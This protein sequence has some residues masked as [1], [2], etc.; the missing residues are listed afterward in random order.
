M[1]VYFQLFFQTKSKTSSF[2]YS[3]SGRVPNDESGA[4]GTETVHAIERRDVEETFNRQGSENRKSLR[5]AQGPHDQRQKYTQVHS[6]EDDV[7]Q[8][9]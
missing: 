7:H 6:Y 9:I 1:I 2:S 8:K 4:C 5:R 3:L